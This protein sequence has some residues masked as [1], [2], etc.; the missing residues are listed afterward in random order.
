MKK[1]D[2]WSKKSK[3]KNILK[4]EN[5]HWNIKKN[6]RKKAKEEMNDDRR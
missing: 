6:E 5:E 2:K 1:E 3:R 4:G